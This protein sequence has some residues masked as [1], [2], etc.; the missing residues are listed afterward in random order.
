[1]QLH[2]LVV[3]LELHVDRLSGT[4]SGQVGEPGDDEIGAGGRHEWAPARE[5]SVLLLEINV[6]TYRMYR[7]RRPPA[8]T[9][10]DPE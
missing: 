2:Q 5:N 9:V 4:G 10:G 8:V 3:E 1:L 6:N 7:L